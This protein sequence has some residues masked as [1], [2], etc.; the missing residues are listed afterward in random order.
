[1][2]ITSPRESGT[3]LR[4]VW[5]QDFESVVHACYT[6][7]TYTYIAINPKCLLSLTQCTPNL[8]PPPPTRSFAVQTIAFNSAHTSRIS[9]IGPRSERYALRRLR[10][11][12]AS[13]GH[14]AYGAFRLL[15]SSSSSSSS[16]GIIRLSILN[17]YSTSSTLIIKSPPITIAGIISS[18]RKCPYPYP[19]SPFLSFI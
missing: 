13:L 19:S 17:A 8:F 12:H 15:S 7:Y 4:W 16:R 1:M 9:H 18:S 2:R 3:R 14:P 11:F 5:R 10:C 6:N